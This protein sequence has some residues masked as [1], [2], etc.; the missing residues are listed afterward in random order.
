[1]NKRYPLVLAFVALLS[2]GNAAADPF[3]G[4]YLGPEIAYDNGPVDFDQFT[5]GGIAGFNLPLSENVYI[6]LEGEASGSTFDNID[7]IFGGHAQIGYRVLPT[8]AVFARAGYREFDFTFGFA[9]GDATYG[10]GGQVFLTDSVAVR[11]IV[12]TLDFDTVGFRAALVF[13]F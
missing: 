8:V 5:F 7:F 4:F 12:D 1:M 10:V 13:E 11:G 6:G 9:G 2:A 3:S